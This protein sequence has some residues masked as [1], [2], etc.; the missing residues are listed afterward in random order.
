MWEVTARAERSE[1]IDGEPAKVWS[2]LGSPAGWSLRA[3]AS[4]MF[5]VPAAE[6]LRLC[7]GPTVYAGHAARSVGTVLFEICDQVPGTMLRLRALPGGRQEFRLLARPADGGTTRVYIELSRVV[8]GWSKVRAEGQQHVEIKAWLATLRAVIEGR[9]RWPDHEMP[10]D[11]RDACMAP[12]MNYSPG[13]V[14]GR[15][16]QR[17][18]RPGV[19]NRAFAGYSARHDGDARGL[20]W[21]RSRNSR[22][23]ARRNAVRHLPRSRRSPQRLGRH[24]YGDQ[25]RAQRCDAH[26]R[27]GWSRAALPA[28]CRI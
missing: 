20:Q 6:P 22:G 10:A 15:A 12:E 23:P 19:G 16:G 11:V 7:V 27:P 24:H 2:L 26:S 8:A 9:A 1:I 3:P 4:F 18:P 28:D 25:P 21:L 5:D 14:R 17:R 13:R